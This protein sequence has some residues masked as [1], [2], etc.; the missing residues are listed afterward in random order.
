MVKNS[1]SQKSIDYCALIK[2]S[3][4]IIV[5]GISLLKEEYHQVLY[6][7]LKNMWDRLGEDVF[8]K[9]EGISIHYFGEDEKKALGA[10]DTDEKFLEINACVY[11][12]TPTKILKPRTHTMFEVAIAHELWHYYIEEFD[13]KNTEEWKEVEK[14]YEENEELILGIF[15]FIGLCGY[16][17]EK[18]STEFIVEAFTLLEAGLLNNKMKNI[19]YIKIFDFVQRIYNS[20]RRNKK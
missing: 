3:F 4:G 9:L 11:G 7:I 16:P 1:T 15:D 17:E 8:K 13:F 14:F 2:Q 20:L 18:R 5:F 6:T 19:N 10:Y 12:P